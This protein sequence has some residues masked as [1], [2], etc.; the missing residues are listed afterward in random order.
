MTDRTH[1]GLVIGKFYP[2]HVGHLALIRFAAE[3]AECVTVVVMGSRF[4]TIDGADRVRW[5]TQDTAD[6]AAVTVLRVLCDAP[7]DYS[8]D[9]AW[10]AN[11]ALIRAALDTAG[12][13]PVDTVFSS[14]SY[15][16]RLAGAF[17]AD[18]VV[19]DA[20]RHRHRMSGTAVREDL[21][22][23]WGDLA[24]S[25]QQDL[26]VRVICVGAASTG[27][28]TLARDLVAHYQAR[29][30]LGLVQPRDPHLGD[31]GESSGD[32]VTRAQALR[33]SEDDAAARC[34]LVIADGDPLAVELRAMSLG[35]P[36]HSEV[37]GIRASG[38]SP[39]DVYLVSDHHDVPVRDGVDEASRAE[40]TAVF[41]TE[42][43]RRGLSWLLLRG[44]PAERCDYASRLIDAI[45]G[46]NNHFTSPP[47]AERTVLPGSR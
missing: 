12:R 38:L 3:Q 27:A 32:L 1:H 5:L 25:A 42:L 35:D 19:F 41:T 6:L 28:T 11:V 47:W 26:A 17:G 44:T 10:H 33:K 7:V 34:P 46:Q 20:Q 43:T 45:W 4:E 8:S 29:G 9:T 30:F 24:P 21:A 22:G 14:E 15:G 40:L 36:A 13:P 39:R 2:P 37:D 18:T 23:C 31:L 16:S